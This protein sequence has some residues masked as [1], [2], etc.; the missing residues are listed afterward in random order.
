MCIGVRI[1]PL[2]LQ[3][4]TKM[5][6]I[7][8]NLTWEMYFKPDAPIKHCTTTAIII[9]TRLDDDGDETQF[10][11]PLN[12]KELD[13]VL[14]PSGP[15]LLKMTFSHHAFRGELATPIKHRFMQASSYGIPLPEPEW[16]R[17]EPFLP[18]TTLRQFMER[19]AEGPC[20]G[21]FHCVKHVGPITRTSYMGSK[22]IKLEMFELKWED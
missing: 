10:R 19:I 7:V 16:F 5:N 17:E 12:K 22:D 14:H 8:N 9:D 18:T 4:Q 1:H 2:T 11:R 3:K 20:S 15:W 21:H 13:T 6:P